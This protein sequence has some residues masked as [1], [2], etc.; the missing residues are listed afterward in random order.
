MHK[1]FRYPKIFETLK[2]CPRSFSAL[3]DQNVSTEKHDIPLI[4]HKTVWKQNFSQKQWGYLLKVFGTM[5]YTSFDWKSWDAPSYTKIFFNARL[6][7]EKQKVFLQSFSF[8]SCETKN[9]QNAENSSIPEFIRNAEVFSYKF[10]CHCQKMSVQ[11]SL[12]ISHSN[13]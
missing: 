8:R 3:W 6:F 4:I 1:I 5:R 10:H 7:S 12:V 13:A 11:R 2:W 9:R